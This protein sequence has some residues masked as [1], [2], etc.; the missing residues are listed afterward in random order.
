MIY[1]MR[2][3]FSI[4]RTLNERIRISACNTQHTKQTG[5]SLKDILTFQRSCFVHDIPCLG[6][7]IPE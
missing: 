4:A 6:I 1:P 2:E 3:K 7:F 5:F